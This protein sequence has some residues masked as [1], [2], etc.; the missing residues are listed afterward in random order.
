ML[1]I[2]RSLYD[3]N[4]HSSETKSNIYYKTV[5]RRG[6]ESGEYLHVKVFGKLLKRL[7]IIIIEGIEA[8][9]I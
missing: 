1:F 5:R 3:K 7:T 4:T 8:S 2:I 6:K 9:V